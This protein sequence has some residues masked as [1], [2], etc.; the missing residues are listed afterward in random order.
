MKFGI[1]V[2]FYFAFLPGLLAQKSYSGNIL[3][4][5]DKTYLEGVSVEI[6]G[7]ESVDTTN[8]R[9]YFSVKGH[10]GDTLRVSF[11]G[12]IEQKIPLGEETFLILQI[13]DKARL[14]PTFE[15]KSEPYAFRFKDGK[16]ILVDPDEEKG[17]STKGG[18]SA[19]YRE[20]PDLTG[21][22]AIAGVLSSLTKRSRQEREYQKKL[23]WMRRRAG[24]YEVVESDSIRQNL[25][26][27]YQLQRSD[28]DKII[29]RFNEGNAYHEFLDWS[30]DR[31]YN[32]LNEFIERERRW[33]N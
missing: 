27:K 4:A 21:G 30:K 3:D 5:T 15:V 22:V 8:V 25:M 9:G 16:L 32:T 6:I 7:S 26:I 10:V 14:L 2:L 11:P 18:I 33:I 29:I 23:E 12:F 1:L 28:W 19:G 17:P 24:Y 13:Q 31:V 20:S